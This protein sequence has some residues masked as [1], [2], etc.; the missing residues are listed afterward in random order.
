[1]AKM[2][3]AQQKRMIIAIDKKAVKLAFNTFNPR[4][5]SAQDYMA[6]EKILTKAMNRIK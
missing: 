1:M 6:I 5:L 3:K 4:V 2:T